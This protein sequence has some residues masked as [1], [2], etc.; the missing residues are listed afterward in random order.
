ERLPVTVLT[1]LAV[2]LGHA[3]A[4]LVGGTDAG[5]LPDAATLQLDAQ[6]VFVVLIA[7]QLFVETA[8]AL[9][10]LARPGPQIDGVHRPVVIEAARQRPP[11]DP[12]RLECCGNGALHRGLRAIASLNS[13]RAAHIVGARALP[14]VPALREVIS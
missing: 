7:H 10:G 5:R 11:T 1:V 3:G 9:E 14:R 6:I 13:P 4:R 8:I 12:A 2:H